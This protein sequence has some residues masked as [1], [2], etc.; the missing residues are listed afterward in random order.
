MA[1]K[2]FTNFQDDILSFDLREAMLGVLNP[3][4]YC[5][6]DTFSPAVESGGVI[7]ITMRHTASGV[8]KPNKAIPPVNGLQFGVIITPQGM[9]IQDDNATIPIAI[10][11]GSGNGG[12]TRYDVIYAE[13]A[14][15]DG[16]PG[17]NPATYDIRKGTPG[18]GTPTLLTP[19]M[20]VALVLVTIPNGAT[21]F[22]QLT[23]TPF[24]A[25]ELGDADTLGALLSVTGDQTYTE[26][27]FIFNDESF[28][29]SL[30]KLD[31]QLKDDHDVV[32]EVEARAL[33]SANWGA[34]TDILSQNTSIW[35]HGLMPKLPG[36][37][38]RRYVY[39]TNNQ[40]I[41]TSDPWV[42]LN[43][44]IA[45][46]NTYSGGGLSYNTNGYLDVATLLGVSGI[47]EVLVTIYWDRNGGNDGT[48]V[49]NVSLA[50]D[51]NNRDPL[52]L[53]MFLPPDDLLR[54]YRQ[55]KDGVV[56]VVNGSIYLTYTSLYGNV[57]DWN[58][59]VLG[60]VLSITFRAYKLAFATL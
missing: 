58:Y 24:D 2:Q 50:S 23:L 19:T 49:G 35:A 39:D 1:Q 17:D 4:R 40:W 59:P 31:M 57:S 52:T 38:T 36:S 8:R 44:T 16:V 37:Q 18:A 12:S 47:S 15:L 60:N 34:L 7:N 28:T 29:D 30:D 48:A 46:I 41:T 53:E 33:D 26:Q 54:A 25:P 56:R 55:S 21:T 14:Y 22:S 51:S 43:G 5:G 6:F 3:G 42:W 20:Q 11:D 9:V 13:H 45:P 10:D 32:T 27:N